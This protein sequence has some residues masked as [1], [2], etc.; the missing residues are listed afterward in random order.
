MNCLYYDHKTDIN[1][2]HINGIYYRHKTNLYS[3]E[4]N[5]LYYDHM[6]DPW[7]ILLS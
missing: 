6:N 2:D 1:S 5:G 3:D 4:F 7:L